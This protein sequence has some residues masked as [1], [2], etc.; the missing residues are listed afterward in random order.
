[1]ELRLVP[2]PFRAFLR[3][4]VRLHELSDHATVR[5]GGDAEIAVQEEVAQ[6]VAAPRRLPALDVREGGGGDG[7]SVTT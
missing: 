5:G 6:P 7:G 2:V 1:V 4:H 3:C